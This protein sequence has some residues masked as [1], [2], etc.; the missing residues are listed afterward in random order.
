MNGTCA[1]RLK[2]TKGG[3]M[4]HIERE[5]NLSRQ[6]KLIFAGG[7]FTAAC[8]VAG[9]FCLGLAW[10]DLEERQRAIVAEHR[11]NAAKLAALRSD[12][13]DTLE[14]VTEAIEAQRRLRNLVA[15]VQCNPF[16]G[17]K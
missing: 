2:K 15:N 16:K 14:T 1:V 9:I 12:H 3:A 11:A 5:N 13:A 6:E 8:L 7:C 17:G 4:C 10:Q